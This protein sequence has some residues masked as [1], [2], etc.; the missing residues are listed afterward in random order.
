[1]GKKDTSRSEADATAANLTPIDVQQ[2]EFRVS[3]FGGY[4]MRDVDEFLDQ[5][6][7]SFSALT[8]E[9]ERLRA[10]GA[11]PV[12]GA[13]DLDDVSRQADEIIARARAEA[14]RITG[15]ARA[16]AGSAAVAGGSAASGPQERAAVNAFITREREFLQSLAGLVQEHAETVKG[17]AKASRPAQQPASS[18]SA[19]NAPS[20]KA[21]AAPKAAEPAPI[22]RAVPAAAPAS[23]TDTAPPTP[24]PTRVP[25][26]ETTVRI[27]EPAAASAPAG[28]GDADP[29][30][31]RSLR[32][33][34][35][36]ED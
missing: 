7:D 11:A 26:T 19:T 2:K 34:F 24:E 14:A 4:K 22:Q 8:A 27:E 10:G 23:A 6:T 30:G 35:W 12:V 36:G 29:E 32:E 25:D 31:D 13:P 15:E 16:A 3:R 1:M 28:R 21:S 33:L 18:A 5:I 9:N 17:M 20:D